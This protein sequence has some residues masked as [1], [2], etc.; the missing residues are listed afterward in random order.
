MRKLM[1]PAGIFAGTLL[2]SAPAMAAGPQTWIS[3]S[4]TDAGACPIGADFVEKLSG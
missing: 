2:L 4:G 3:A 1:A